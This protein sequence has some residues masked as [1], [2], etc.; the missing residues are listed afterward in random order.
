MG[1]DK[2]CRQRVNS[3]FRE[4][5]KSGLVE[6]RD[7]LLWIRDSNALEKEVVPFE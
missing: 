6:L 5:E 4:W 3:I 1:D 7:G 2:T